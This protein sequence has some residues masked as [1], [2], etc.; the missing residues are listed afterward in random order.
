MLSF[1]RH[2]EETQSLLTN[3]DDDEI[4]DLTNLYGSTSGSQESEE[5]NTSANTE[6][7]S[8]TLL[9]VV[10]GVVVLALV[11]SIMVVNWAK[12]IFEEDI[13][14]VMV[15]IV[16][17]TAN[18]SGVLGLFSLACFR[19]YEWHKAKLE[20]KRIPN[21][22]NVKEITFLK[23]KRFSMVLFG[24]C[25]IIH[26][27][28]YAWK[29]SIGS[30]LNHHLG[31]A[32]N[33]ITIL[34]VVCL[35]IY[36]STHQQKKSKNKCGY[37]ILSLTLLIA[38]VSIWLDT[39]FSESGYLFNSNIG[40]NNTQPMPYSNS[41]S[42]AEEAIRKTDPYFLPAT[43][44]FSLITIDMLFYKKKE[45]LRANR[46][47]E[48]TKQKVPFI[49]LLLQVIVFMASFTL[50]IF[51]FIV[52]LTDS[53]DKNYANDFLT[54][55]C[56]QLVLKIMIFALIVPCT[57]LVFT[58]LRFHFNI[59]AFVLIF[60][61]FGNIVYHMFYL[62]SFFSKKGPRVKN[63]V[64][65]SITDNSVSI[66]I[67]FFQTLFLLGIDSPKRTDSL[68]IDDPGVYGRLK[69]KF[70]HYSCSLLGIINMGLWV[71]E[72]FGEGR[73]PVF[74]IEFYEA[75]DLPVWIIFNKLIL[76]LTIFFRFHSGL[77][78]MKFYT[79]LY[80]INPFRRNPANNPF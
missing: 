2:R 71:C 68:M 37:K 72:S 26:C 69:D 57:I 64:P 8:G 62:Y 63:S 50:F 4:T 24:L 56:I 65:I 51:T 33:I 67:A 3:Y 53:D 38:N 70:I 60:P 40:Q 42:R 80:Y 48:E 41:T 54:Y 47:P 32:Y 36:F 22:P 35:Y 61:C 16:L 30:S 17:I 74:S 15:L 34:Y 25:Y 73:L 29:H 1:K 9:M 20:N 78:F 43:I 11:V 44:E 77:H 31:M 66:L 49:P 58:S 75:Y 6:Q 52:L 13:S 27:V 55:V 79:E 7:S 5:E 21:R 46:T 18:S 39:I 12:L 28:L 19:I 45:V 59:S 76:P 14:N 23:V 10:L